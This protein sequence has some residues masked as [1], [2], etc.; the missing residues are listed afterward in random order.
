MT[1]P[2]VTVDPAMNFGAPSIRGV[3]VGTI[4]ELVWAGEA[5]DTVAAE[6]DLT[7]EQVLTACWFLGRFGIE[8]A[9][10]AARFGAVWRKR[11]G[12]WAWE[13]DGAMWR[14]EYDLVPDP[15]TRKAPQK[16]VKAP[17][18]DERPSRRMDGRSEGGE[19]AQ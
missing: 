17:R 1:R 19:A 15:P 5:V 7:C 11:W 8:D 16:P 18:S 9:L 14:G 10:P 4:G 3:R 13:V 6:Y 2:V 12:T